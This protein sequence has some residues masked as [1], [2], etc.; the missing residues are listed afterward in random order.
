M[1]LFANCRSLASV[2]IAGLLSAGI[3][4]ADDCHPSVDPLKAQY[5]IRCIQLQSRVSGQDMDFVEQCIR[6]T[7]G[8]SEHWVNDRIYPRRPFHYQP[9]AFVI[10]KYLNR[11]LPEFV[12]SV[13]IE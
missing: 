1:S 9:N 5:I 4:N 7:G 13:R 12:N 8:W 3:A 6:T 2:V 11:L 10:D